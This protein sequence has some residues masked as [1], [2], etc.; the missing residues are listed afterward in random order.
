MDRLVQG[1]ASPRGMAYLIRAA[2]VNAWL[3]GRV[4]VVPEDLRAM[5]TEVMAHR[6]FL[7]PIY[8]MRRDQI[9]PELLASALA[10][11]AAP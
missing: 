3:E 11:V 7:D 1:G 10:K 9:M 2:R 4:M 6:V 8:E 5:F